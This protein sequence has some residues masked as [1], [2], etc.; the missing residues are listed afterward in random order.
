MSAIDGAAVLLEDNAKSKLMDAIVRRLAFENVRTRFTGNGDTCLYLN[1]RG[2][3]VWI[4][5][6]CFATTKCLRSPPKIAKS[7]AQVSAYSVRVTAS[8]FVRVCYASISCH[9]RGFSIRGY[10]LGQLK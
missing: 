2:L 7:Y 10:L 8:T 6:Q 3:Y 5:R 1:I 9:R 4:S